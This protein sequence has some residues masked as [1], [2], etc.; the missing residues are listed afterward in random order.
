MTDFF[1]D[2]FN[3]DDALSIG[4]NYTVPC[5]QVGIFDESVLPVAESVTGDSPFGPGVDQKTQVLY[6]ASALDSANQIIRCVWGHDDVTPTGVDEPPSFTILARMSKDPLIL[7]L[8]GDEEPFCYDQGYGLRVTCPINGSAPV[9]KLIKF[10]T[11]RRAPGLNRPSSSEIDGAQVL[12]SMT[13]QSKHLTLDPTWDGTGNIPYRGFWQDMRLRVRFGED[14]VVLDAF[15]NDVH[16]NTPILSYTDQAD[17]VWSDVG[18]PGFEFISARRTT[19]PAGA[20]PF[21]E[22]AKALMRCTLFTVDSIVVV[23]RPVSVTPSNYFT[24]RRLV[25]RVITHVEKNGDAKFTATL[26]GDTKLQTYLDFVIEAELA[27]CRKEGYW[28]W[29]QRRSTIY[30]ADGVEEYELP[31][32]LAELKAVLPG[33][34]NAAPLVGLDEVRFLQRSSGIIPIGGSPAA[35]FLGEESVNARR[36][37]RVVPVPTIA[38]DATTDPYLTIL[39]YGRPVPPALADINETYPTIPQH[40]IDVL[41]YSAVAHALLLDT[42]AQNTQFYVSAARSKLAELQ[43]EN[44]RLMGT[45]QLVMVSA[46][47]VGAQVLQRPLTRATSLDGFGF[48]L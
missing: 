48:L 19:Q 41:T 24:Y 1:G 34:W 4:S 43:R 17:P 27:I 12:T 6:T 20:S 35:Y 21:E 42:D 37:L 16:L 32:D 26:A 14:K 46:A 8:G 28:H 3:R 13:L 9:L 36:T 15:L 23:R 40:H 30:L 10:L 33:T 31:E 29:L 38:E 47:D 25:D 7:N 11:A 39:Y 45:Q 44:N 5:G 18:R 2:K 22:S